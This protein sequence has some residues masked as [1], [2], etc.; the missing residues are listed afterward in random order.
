MFTTVWSSWSILEH[1]LHVSVV[2]KHRGLHVHNS[3]VFN[4]MFI[5]DILELSGNWQH[6]SKLRPLFALYQDFCYFVYQLGSL[7]MASSHFIAIKGS[8][9][10]HQS[11]KQ[12]FSAPSLV[13][14]F[15]LIFTLITLEGLFFASGLKRAF[16]IKD[17]GDVIVYSWTWWVY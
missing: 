17:F 5:W 1:G 10:A 15:F 14:C 13:F 9:G 7:N 12:F 16:Q 8:Y 11:P 2:N 3:M 6:A 4:N